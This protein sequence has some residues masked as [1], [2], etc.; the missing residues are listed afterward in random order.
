MLGAPTRTQEEGQHMGMG[1]PGHSKVENT[2][3]SQSREEV[4]VQPSGCQR[5]K[6]SEANALGVLETQRNQR[7]EK[8][9]NKGYLVAIWGRTEA[10][11]GASLP[12]T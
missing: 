8:G 3:P 2:K 9:A 4:C 12:Q 1:L 5:G 11:H 10:A 6:R 7:R